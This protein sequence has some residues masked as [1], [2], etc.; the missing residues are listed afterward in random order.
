HL[1]DQVAAGTAVEILEQDIARLHLEPPGQL[2]PI[3]PS[4]RFPSSPGGEQDRQS[5]YGGEDDPKETVGAQ[6][7]LGMA[8][9]KTL[10]SGLGRRE[11]KAVRRSGGLQPRRARGR[12]PGAG[13]R[14]APCRPPI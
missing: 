5:R 1:P 13:T 7:M 12:V 2:A 10:Q 8:G 9:R 3:Q 11:S 4:F 6:D 14:S